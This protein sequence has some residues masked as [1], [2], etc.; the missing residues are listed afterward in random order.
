MRLNRILPLAGLLLSTA[1]DALLAAGPSG[2]VF[3]VNPGLSLWTTLVFL[4]LLAIL[5]KYAWGPILGAAQ[6]REE[7]IQ[8]ALDEAR[9]RNEKA[10]ELLRE[11]KA[12]LADAR[13][14]ANELIADGKAAGERV[15]REIEEKARQEAQNIVERARAE[16]HRERDAA[17]DTVRTE[18]V[19]LALAAAAQLLERKLDQPT[20]RQLVESFLEDMADESA[21]G[22]QGAEA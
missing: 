4:A 12:Q 22:K 3:D 5:S 6:A 10:E 15:R 13:R 11:H 19:D 8:S 17:L 16:I 18:A 9:Q 14:Q 7:T 21:A 20:D 2:G 1:P